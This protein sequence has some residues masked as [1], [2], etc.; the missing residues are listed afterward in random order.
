MPLLKISNSGKETAFFIR[1]KV[2]NKEDELVLP[3]FF[4][5]N[6]FTLLPGDV[7]KVE[8]DF[9]FNGDKIKSDDLKLVV[10]GWNVQRNRDKILNRL[11]RE[12]TI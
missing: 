10:E 6:Y 1:L 11:S 8:L 2:V 5:E 4:T 7:K 9:S 3:S 12:I